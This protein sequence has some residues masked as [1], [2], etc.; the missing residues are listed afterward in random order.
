[1]LVTQMKNLCM[2]QYVIDVLTEYS[3][4]NMFTLKR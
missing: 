2:L 4:N 1:M 3:K